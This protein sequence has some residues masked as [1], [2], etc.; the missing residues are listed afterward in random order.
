MS[1]P[2]AAHLP[3]D[4]VLLTCDEVAGLLRVS[5]S[6]IY[7][8][9]ASGRLRSVSAS[10]GISR[11]S[12]RWRLIDVKNFLAGTPTPAVVRPSRLGSRGPR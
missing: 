2:G 10:T 5:R 7:A 4:L 9:T 3:D 12:R 11:A 6:T 8:L 1:G